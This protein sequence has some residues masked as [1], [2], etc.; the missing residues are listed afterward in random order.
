[1]KREKDTFTVT[2]GNFRMPFSVI[3]IINRQKKL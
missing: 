2:D 1:M 3:D